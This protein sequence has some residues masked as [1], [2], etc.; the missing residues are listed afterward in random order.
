M[1]ATFFTGQGRDA[2]SS[3]DLSFLLP[4]S[5]HLLSVVLWNPSC[6]LAFLS[7]G[8]RPSPGGLPL[9][10]IVD[11]ISLI[12]SLGYDGKALHMRSGAYISKSVHIAPTV[13][14]C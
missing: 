6:I 7:R 4:A 10:G 5:C 3:T 2:L 14:L 8:P 13:S 9:A 12:L 1:S 11:C